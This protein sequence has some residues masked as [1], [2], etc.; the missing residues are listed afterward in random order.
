MSPTTAIPPH[1]SYCS[2]RQLIARSST[3]TD[4][5]IK[6]FA[7]ILS[8]EVV[9]FTTE[10]ISNVNHRTAFTFMEC[11]E[12]ARSLIVYTPIPRLQ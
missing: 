11:A 1:I 8:H 6:E 3:F 9:E 2:P 4:H 5:R 12:L 10:S 7:E